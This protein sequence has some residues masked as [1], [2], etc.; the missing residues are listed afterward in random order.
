[1]ESSKEQH[2]IILCIIVNVFTVIFDQFS[3]SSL[4]QS[5]YW[6]SGNVHYGLL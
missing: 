3:A 5:V 1:M 4:N 2:L 6:L